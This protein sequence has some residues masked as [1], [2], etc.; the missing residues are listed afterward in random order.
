[1]GGLASLCG[2]SRGEEAG[3]EP[4]WEIRD[5][6]SIVFVRVASNGCTEERDFVVQTA[7]N[8]ATSKLR[9]IRIIR[10]RQDDCKMKV[11]EGKVLTIKKEKLGLKEYEGFFLANPIS[12]SP[13]ARW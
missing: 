11:V 10:L 4:V 6:P 5:S 8:T 7:S 1:V 13:D 3:L 9:T 2:T 12:A